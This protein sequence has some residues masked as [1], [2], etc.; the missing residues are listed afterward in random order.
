MAS[1]LRR[2][3]GRNVRPPAASIKFDATNRV[4]R[5]QPDPLSIG[6][7]ND[8]TCVAL[9]LFWVS[10]DEIVERCGTTPKFCAVV[11]DVTAST[12]ER[13]SIAA[14]LPSAAL[15]DSVPWLT[16]PHGAVETAILTANLCSFVFDYCARQKVAGLHLRGHYLAQMP[17]IQFGSILK[18]VPWEPRH[19]LRDGSPPGHS[20]FRIPHGTFSCSLRIVAGL[21]RPLVGTKNDAFY[22]AVNWTPPS[23]TSI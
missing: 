20:S 11:K 16:T 12:N 4:R 7:H 8:P 13:T 17:L 19:V 6:E 23:F 1:S 5:N 3:D 22:S 2:Q 9:P 10:R 18:V 21:G 15:T 14:L